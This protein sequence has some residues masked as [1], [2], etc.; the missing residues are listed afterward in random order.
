MK[1]ITILPWHAQYKRFRLGIGRSG[2]AGAYPLHMPF[3]QRHHHQRQMSPKGHMCP[4][5]GGFAMFCSS[6][7]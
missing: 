5:V 4:L 3:H 7:V 6:D 2:P 1:D